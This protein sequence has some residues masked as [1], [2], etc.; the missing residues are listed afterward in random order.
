MLI[1][2]CA[3]GGRRNDLE[4]MRRAVPL[5]R[6]DFPFEPTAHQGMTYGISMWLP[7]YGTGTVANGTAP[8]YGQGVMPVIPYAFWSSACPSYMS[9]IDIRQEDYDY[10]TLRRLWSEWR[11]LG[12]YFYGDYYPLTPFSRKT[13]VWIAWQ[14]HRSDKGDGFIAAFRRPDAEQEALNL[15][16]RGLAPRARY[17]F[18]V[19]DGPA[20]GSA[21][22]T[23]ERLMTDGLPLVLT[24]RPE[25]T[26]I[27]YERL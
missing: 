24:H 19:I 6:S 16:L 17:R 9:E 7:F 22:L 13:D 14:F 8:Y 1:D 18:T 15:R 12:P 10:G 26:V 2:S 21:E 11:Q 27:R 23:G 20:L 3:S 5:W 25:C 4:T